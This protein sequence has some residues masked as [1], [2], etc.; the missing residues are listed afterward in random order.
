MSDFQKIVIFMGWCPRSF[1]LK[2]I[3]SAF[4]R[5]ISF[6]GMIIIIKFSSHRSQTAGY[7]AKAHSGIW[8]IPSSPSLSFPSRPES[9]INIPMIFIIQISFVIPRLLGRVKKNGLAFQV[10]H[11]EGFIPHAGYSSNCP[12]PKKLPCGEKSERLQREERGKIWR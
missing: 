6:S 4:F 3:L 9:I 5:I 12:P 8:K 1:F 7:A 11:W 2:I 10:S